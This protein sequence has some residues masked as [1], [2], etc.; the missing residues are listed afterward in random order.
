MAV[1]GELGHV[2]DDAVLGQPLHLVDGEDE[3]LGHRLGPVVHAVAPVGIDAVAGADGDEIG[4][5]RR[6]GDLEAG[7]GETHH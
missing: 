1:V 5:Q 2:V 7:L 4:Q 3:T 6:A